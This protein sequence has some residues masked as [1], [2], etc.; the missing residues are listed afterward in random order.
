MFEE[1]NTLYRRIA[2]IGILLVILVYSFTGEKLPYNNGLGWDGEDYFNI[3]QN[4]SDL[5]LSHGI[6]SYHIQRIL[7]FAIVHY[8]HSFFEIEV[9]TQSAIAGC[10][11]LNFICILLTAFYFFKISINRQWNSKTET[12]AFAICFFNVPILKFFGYYSLLTDCPAY[13]LSYMAIYYYLKDN[14]YM[15]TFVGIMAMV[16]WPILALVIWILAFF[17]RT[18]VKDLDAT[19]KHSTILSSLVRYV[20]VLWLPLLFAGVSAAMSYL[21]PERPFMEWF[22]H[23]HPINFA[24]AVACILVTALLFYNASKAFRLGWKEVF[25][26]LFQKKNLLIIV[27]SFVGF[28]ALYMTS[29]YYGGERSFSPLGQIV[30]LQEYPASDILVVLETPFLFLGIFVLL[31][32]LLWKDY[33]KEVCKKYGIGGLLTMMFGLIFITEIETRKLISFYPVFLIPL[34]D[35]IGKKNLKDWVPVAFV[36]VALVLSFFWWEINVPGIEESYITRIDNYRAFPAQRYFMFM[37]PWQC[38]EVYVTV[39]IIEILLGVVIVF[40]H[41]KG[42]LYARE[43]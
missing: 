30:A 17:P 16:T 25:M 14:K 32:I 9:T 18:E 27:G 28:V 43:K 6:N 42:L 19:D 24:H 33:V 31:I 5:Y 8:V 21:H 20:Y 15:E 26:T 36:I 2:L 4:F 39:S 13:L 40:L 10:S 11:I 23:R 34:M 22:N 29:K 38:R 3:L 41:K 35:V 7:P 37:G 1:R 12:I